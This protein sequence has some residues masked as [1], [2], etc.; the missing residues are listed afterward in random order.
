MPR[1]ITEF[2]NYGVSFTGAAGTSLAAGAVGNAVLT[3][4]ASSDFIWYYG[5]WSANITSADTAWTEYTRQRPSINILMT[6]GD[7]SS[8]LMN[9]AVPVSHFFG[10]GEM[11]FVLPAPRTIPARSTMSFQVTNLDDA[12]T[13]DLYLTMIGVKRYTY[14]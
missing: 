12:I 10:S 9:Q 2:F 13:Y 6:P 7:T 8:Q 3:F 11:P 14:Q 5:A 1:S 4:D